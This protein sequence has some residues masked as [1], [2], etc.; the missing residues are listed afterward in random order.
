MYAKFGDMG[1]ARN[2]FDEM[3]ERNL[4]T[5]TSLV[6]GYVR[7][8]CGEEGLR[9]FVKMR[10]EGVKGNEFTYGS[11]LSACGS[12]RWLRC[13]MGVQGC[14]AKSGLFGDVFVE[15]ALV[16]MYLR[17]GKMEDAWCVFDGM[18]VKDLVSWNSMI[19]GFASLG[20]CDDAL[21][22]FRLMLRE[23]KT[24]D[25]FT[26]ANVLM[27]SAR[28]KD[29]SNVTQLHGF[30][31]KLGFESYNSLN[32][33]LINAYSKKGS[34]RSADQI[35]RNMTEKDMVSCTALIAGYA[36]EG[37]NS[38]NAVNLFIELR[39]VLMNVDSV[40][41]C[42]MVN[43][44]ANSALLSLGK[45]IHALSLKC[46]AFHDVPMNNAL[47]DMYSKSGEIFD[48]CRVFNEMKAKNVISWT[49]LIAG[50]GKHGYGHNAVIV[51][52]E[53][54][55][56]GYEPN[57]ITF[58]SLLFS[59]SHSGLITEG[60][61]CFN[62][63]VSKYNILPQ[64]KHYSC[65]VDLLARGG[66]I[67][68]AYHLI[69]K[70]HMK[71]D[72]SVWGAMLG[73]CSVY[74]NVSIAGLW[75]GVRDIRK[76][77][78]VKKLRKQSGFSLF[79]SSNGGCVACFF[80]MV[81]KDLVSWNSMIGGF[82][83]R[84]FCDDAFLMFR[85]MLREGMTPDNFTMASDLMASAQGKD[86]LKEKNDPEFAKK[87][88]SLADLYAFGTAHRAHAS[89]EGVAKYLKP[90]VA[91]YLMQKELD[92]LVGAVSSP[93][94][95]FAATVGG[96]KVSSKIGVIESLLEKTF[97]K[98]SQI[99]VYV[100]VKCAPNTLIADK[101]AANANSK[102][103]PA[104]EIPGGWMGLDIGPDSIKS[105]SETLVTTKT[106]TIW[107]LWVYLRWT[108][109][110]LEPRCELILSHVTLPDNLDWFVRAPTGEGPFL[111]GSHNI[112]DLGLFNNTQENSQ[113]W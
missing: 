27:A 28:G 65:M 46:L 81:V 37:N 42:S 64:A 48:A 4:V 35:Y 38:M 24:P 94:K 76:F 13:G 104:K 72:A 44:C 90:S 95:P 97:S 80:G 9:V 77:M 107:D 63:M 105:F 21:V 23:G 45:Q 83:S 53:M 57:D 52:N 55:N 108:S 54:V 61:Q 2:V 19:G 75:D 32:G 85:L 29:L 8:G 7:N 14:V 110:L 89:T 26:M 67:E 109:L 34:I 51:Y 62:S 1:N 39:Q 101:F 10:R 74:G 82:A 91:G 12:L 11:V 68:E 71:P 111:D 87:L 73:A 5:W 40:I 106:I 31:L 17:C 49:S 88:A 6:S 59:C 18:V 22:M 50:Y 70:M 103:V 30:V 33:S 84:G 112:Y 16:E 99:S 25:N 92:Y 58:L 96:S 113:F 3:R 56:E 98:T 102:V 36:R 100:I 79:Q 20:F 69:Q 43:I 93:N 86:F 78:K 60:K 66:E 15:C 47:I 41:L